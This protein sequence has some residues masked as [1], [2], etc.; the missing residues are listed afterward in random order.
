M[1]DLSTIEEIN[2]SLDSNSGT[3]TQSNMSTSVNNEHFYQI[4]PMDKFDGDPDSLSDWLAMYDTSAKALEWTTIMM[5]K[6]F[7]LHLSGFASK[8]YLQ[9]T[10]TERATW[11]TLVRAFR[12][13][14]SIKDNIQTNMKEFC[15][16]VQKPNEKVI[17][18]GFALKTAAERAIQGD[19][20]SDMRKQLLFTQFIT[21]LRPEIKSHALLLEVDNFDDALKKA[22]LI[23][24]NGLITKGI[25]AID[26]TND[27]KMYSIEDVR[28]L[29]KSSQPSPKNDYCASMSY[30]GNSPTPYRDHSNDRDSG[31]RRNNY[32]RDSSRNRDDHNYRSNRDYSHDRNNSYRSS[33][34]NYRDN[35][36]DRGYDRSYNDYRGR[37]PNRQEFGSKGVN[38]FDRNISDVR[39]K[40]GKYNADHTKPS[41]RDSMYSTNNSKSVNERYRSQSP[42]ENRRPVTCYH[43]GENGHVKTECRKLRNENNQDRERVDRNGKVQCYNCKSFGHMARS[44]PGS[45]AFGGTAT[46]SRKQVGFEKPVNVIER[47]EEKKRIDDIVTDLEKKNMRILAQEVKEQG[48]KN[49]RISDMFYRMATKIGGPEI[50]NSMPVGFRRAREAQKEWGYRTISEKNRLSEVLWPHRKEYHE[51]FDEDMRCRI[52]QHAKEVTP[53]EYIERILR[54]ECDRSGRFLTKE[55]ILAKKREDLMYQWIIGDSS[56]VETDPVKPAVEDAVV[57]ETESNKSLVDNASIGE[58]MISD[59]FVVEKSPMVGALIEES[60]GD[61]VPLIEKSSEVDAPLILE[62][63][64]DDVEILETNYDVLFEVD[65]NDPTE[66]TGY[67]TMIRQTDMDAEINED[68]LSRGVIERIKIILEK[69]DTTRTEIGE[70]INE[71]LSLNAKPDEL[72]QMIPT[73]RKYGEIIPYQAPVKV[74]LQKYGEYLRKIIK[75]DRMTDLE[76][77]T[78]SGRQFTLTLHVQAKV[79]KLRKKLTDI[80]GL[81]KGMMMIIVVNG[82]TVDD[83]EYLIECGCIPT[84]KNKVWI[85]WEYLQGMEP[86]EQIRRFEN[87]PDE[88][89]DLN[90]STT[91][92]KE[93]Y[94]PEV[95]VQG[96]INRND[97]LLNDIIE[98]YGLF[99]DITDKSDEPNVTRAPNQVNKDVPVKSS[100]T[101]KTPPHTKETPMQTLPPRPPGRPPKNEPPGKYAESKKKQ[102]NVR[103]NRVNNEDRIPEITRIQRTRDESPKPG[104]SR[105][106]RNDIN[107]NIGDKSIEEIAQQVGE[108]SKLVDRIKKIKDPGNEEPGEEGWQNKTALPVL[109]LLILTLLGIP[110]I[111][112]LTAYDCEKPKEGPKYSLRDIEACPEAIPDKFEKS[113]R[114]SYYVYQESDFLRTTARECIVKRAQSAW[115]CGQYSYTAMVVPTTAFRPINISTQNCETAFQTGKIRIDEKLEASA[116]VG[117]KTDERFIRQGRIDSDGSCGKEVYEKTVAGVQVKN[118]VIVED[119]MVELKEYQVVFDQS[120]S[121]MMG[122]EY[123]SALHTE[124]FTGESTIIYKVNYRECTLALLKYLEFRELRGSLFQ[125]VAPSTEPALP[126]RNRTTSD[127]PT[128][129]TPT[130]IVSSRGGDM[131]KLL[132][133]DEASRC[134]KIVRTTNY[135]GI[136]VSKEEVKEAKMRIAKEDVNMNH[137]FNNKIDFLYHKNLMKIER[138]YQDLVA[139]DC[140]LNREIL[141]TK[142]AVVMTNQDMV[143]PLLPLAEG[144][145]ARVMGEAIHTYQCKK[146]EVSLAEHGH[147]TNE[148]PV[149]YK[150]EKYFAEPIT[151]VLV[152]TAR[153]IACSAVLSPY[154]WHY[155][156]KW[157]SLPHRNSVPPPL[158]IEMM[159]LNNQEQF[160]EIKSMSEGGIYSQ[161]EINEARK[162]LLFPEKRTR[163]LTEIVYRVLGEHGD[164]SN[165]NFDLLLSPDHFK[166]AAHATL[167]KIWGKFLIFGQASAGLMGIYII[168]VMIKVILSQILNTLHIYRLAGFTWKMV[169]G[170]CPLMARHVLFELNLDALKRNIEKK[171]AA[172]DIEAELI[173]NKDVYKSA[174]NKECQTLKNTSQDQDQIHQSPPCTYP[175]KSIE[176]YQQYGRQYLG[177]AEND[178]FIIAEVTLNGQ[179][180]KGL[181]DTGASVTSIKYD[182]LSRRQKES[183]KRDYRKFYTIN[184]TRVNVRGICYLKMKLFNIT[185]KREVR[186]IDDIP[187]DCVIGLDVIREL[188]KRQIKW[189]SFLPKEKDISRTTTVSNLMM[190]MMRGEEPP[191]PFSD[192]YLEE[193]PN[194][195][196]QLGCSIESFYEEISRETSVERVSPTE[197]II[198]DELKESMR[199]QLNRIR[200]LEEENK[201]LKRMLASQESRRMANEKTMSEQGNIWIA[202]KLLLTTK[203]NMDRKRRIEPVEVY[204]PRKQVKRC[205][206]EKWKYFSQDDKTYCT[207]CIRDGNTPEEIGFHWWNSHGVYLTER[208][209]KEKF[210]QLPTGAF[211][212]KRC[213]FVGMSNEF[214]TKSGALSHWRMSHNMHASEAPPA[215][216]GKLHWSIESFFGITKEPSVVNALDT[217]YGNG[218]VPYMKIRING[219]RVNALLDTGS[220]VTLINDKYIKTKN[221]CKD[222]L[223]GKGVVGAT[224][225]Q[226]NLMGISECDFHIADQF[227]RHDAYITAKDFFYDAIIGMDL[228]TR[229]KNI[230]F[231]F[232]K[233]ILVTEK[234]E[235]V[236]EDIEVTISETI[237][238]PPRSEIIVKGQMPKDITD[239]VL[240]EPSSKFMER[241]EMPVTQGL[242]TVIK[243][244]IPV[245]I[246]NVN[247]KTIKLYPGT[248]IG[249]AMPIHDLTEVIHAKSAGYKV[250]G[251]IDLSNCDIGT[252]EQERLRDVLH[253]FDEVMAKHEYDLGKT[254]VIKHTLPLLDEQ[255]IKQRAY[256]IPYAQQEE[257]KKLIKGMEENEIIRRSSSPWTSPV[258]M[259][260]KKDGSMR[261]CVDYRKLNEITRKDTYPLPRIDEMLDKL[262]RSVIFTTLDL[263]SGYW[264][265][266]VEESDKPKTAFSTGHDLWEFN[267]LPF[268]LT[269]APATFQRCMN[270]LLMDTA[271]AM[272]Y[273]DDIIIFSTSFEEHLE[274]LRAVLDRLWTAGLKIKP[275]KCEFARKKVKFLGHIVSANGIQPDPSNTEKVKNFKTPKT[276]KEVQQFL[277][278]ASYYRRFIKNFAHI[279]APLSELTKKQKDFVWGDKQQAAFEELKERL[280]NPPILRY[281][282]MSADFVLMTDAS[283]FAIGAV[284]GQKVEKEKDHVIAYAS[285]GL[286]AHEKNYSTIEREAL[287]IVFATKQFRHYIWAKKVTLLTDQRPLVWLMKHK[288]SSS[289]L[290]RW[291]LQLQEYN[292]EIQYRAGKANANADC[293]SRLDEERVVAAISRKIDPSALTMNQAQE[294]DDEII[295]IK[296]AIDREKGNHVRVRKDI[297]DHVN[298]NEGKYRMDKGL[299]K[300]HDATDELI[301]LPQKFRTEIMMEYHDGALGGHLSRKKTLGRIKKRYFW[302]TIYADV[303]QWCLDCQ[304]CATR[305]DTGKRTKVPLKPIPPPTSPMEV[306]AMDIVGP[307]P[308]TISG[309]KYIIVFCDYLTKWVEAYPMPNQK[310]ETIA[311]IFVEKIVFRYGVPQKLITDQGTNFL[312]DLMNSISKIFQIMRI[313]TSPYHPQTDGL[314][315]RFNRTLTSMLSSYVNTQQTDWDVHIP[316]CLFAYRNAPHAS[317]GETPFYLMYL[318]HSR[319]PEDVKWVPPQS[320]YMDVI[321]YKTLMMERLKTAWDKAN[322]KMKYNQETMKENYDRKTREHKF[323]VGDDVLIHQ[324][325][326][327]KGLSPKLKR[328][329]KGPYKVLQVTSTNLKLQNKANK[330]AEPIIVHVNRCKL[331]PPEVKKPR[332]ELRSHKNTVAFIGPT[333]QV[334]QLPIIINGVCTKGIVDTGSPI[335]IIASRFL[336]IAQISEAK[337]V[338]KSNY[339]TI[340]GE[341]LQFL[342]I[343]STEFVIGEVQFTAKF[344]ILNNI[345]VDGI[346]GIDVISTISYLK[347]DWIKYVQTNTSEMTPEQSYNSI[348]LITREN[349]TRIEKDKLGD[350][351]KT[352]LVDIGKKEKLKETKMT[353]PRKHVSFKIG[354][355]STLIIILVLLLLSLNDSSAEYVNVTRYGFDMYVTAHKILIR[356]MQRIPGQ[357]LFGIGVYDGSRFVKRYHRN[358]GYTHRPRFEFWAD[359]LKPDT[360]HT[361]YLK[362]FLTNSSTETY[363]NGRWTE[364][365]MI[366]ATRPLYEKHPIVPIKV[367]DKKSSVVKFERNTNS[368]IPVLPKLS[369]SAT[370][371]NKKPLTTLTTR[372]DAYVATSDISLV[373]TETPPTVSQSTTPK[374]LI[375]RKA[376]T[377]KTH[378]TISG[379]DYLLN[380]YKPQIGKTWKYVPYTKE[381]LL[382][383]RSADLYVLPQ[384]PQTQRQVIGKPTS[385]LGIILYTIVPS[386]LGGVVICFLARYINSKLRIRRR[387]RL[388][389]KIK[390]KY[391]APPRLSIDALF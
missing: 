193:L 188:E 387:R 198:P 326:T 356:D 199:Y 258:V 318:R 295:Q 337:P 212:C 78:S 313:H 221:Y 311:Q 385:T 113:A 257:V 99:D 274:D 175:V 168:A 180:R 146:V 185:V 301:V 244:E 84:E 296:K 374:S 323:E 324:P 369:N 312:G 270:F 119:Y 157:I 190:P 254:S 4:I 80:L 333:N 104:G 73:L 197:C 292:L 9:L 201:K 143:A 43:C 259:V 382:K 82:H 72:T 267:V 273:I 336:T 50:A 282:D 341:K 314:V 10:D 187:I 114:A 389:D 269:G 62:E 17:E 8:A 217:P 325:F 173:T 2:S 219:Y 373:T 70:A 145:F 186:I 261:F 181:M 253:E 291:A 122:R 189:L 137:Y 264:Q 348:C 279:A 360:P 38:G 357:T 51:R 232:N 297:K 63:K 147:C 30:R 319:M 69:P 379:H 29:L 245:R 361:I 249:T 229:L 55:E 131:I 233:G 54:G 278:L 46:Q 247:M 23:E 151:R 61:S 238:I 211:E 192:V 248:R 256:R 176:E 106:V 223:I 363:K 148:L 334:L 28:S 172:E 251:E 327:T 167:E 93:L 262:G 71:L 218:V 149:S 15:S 271:H 101:Q 21:G 103:S 45:T 67:V 18:Y 246:S 129:D 115:Y 166:K 381:E 191:T 154:Y 98:T 142:L 222:Q 91:K 280:L 266:E 377:N 275:T 159:K 265:I 110:G 65:E 322:L 163:V 200:V 260:K 372:E 144:S 92:P 383:I 75:I 226:I 179:K 378:K 330:K 136:L 365:R 210:K 370:D 321:D 135:P 303:K 316:Y 126:V 241:Y 128:K 160:S 96:E 376:T 85:Y 309:N 285:R 90:T 138:V 31:Y 204:R 48:V 237:H 216:N 40:Y 331:A 359:D 304:I 156:N 58:T 74:I 7:P 240:F 287:A 32:Y 236:T 388:F 281:P 206:V 112:G 68:D 108:V 22:R 16:R 300:Y 342:G 41:Y 117:K 64:G 111:S 328:P 252:D 299:L 77:Q 306:T 177:F 230:R 329:F 164:A 368:L 36:R 207:L 375:T 205:Q 283:G 234:N 213:D 39:S 24:E 340:T 288:D 127:I 380:K 109:I 250:Y 118:A 123:C 94:T 83:D 320:Q 121:K 276:V 134:G 165:P 42:R 169:L 307:L 355:L 352:T 1:T 97:E 208:P 214:Y 184:N 243:K 125:E 33:N 268:G 345:V 133:K 384:T 308:E 11:D 170:C 56:K 220:S 49:E 89:V 162:F 196:K 242:C 35:S 95:K 290:I 178:E 107:V 6:R 391:D 209:F 367:F 203:P 315:E 284:L 57:R 339:Y 140:R 161:K 105:E 150:G 116:F 235:P 358:I 353:N 183:L 294:E 354:K 362:L 338:K 5:T 19:G 286:K 195:E 132:L 100:F 44:C 59:N 120:T 277:G 215:L 346:V 310:A 302:P 12:K 66:V 351:E 202:P 158:T 37:S 81:I 60:L 152:K 371:L 26:F 347:Q 293:L 139:S 239:D 305:R 174:E 272:V 255:P 344:W 13:K 20:T 289:R 130:V 227:L 194:L 25:R 225:D 171:D 53:Q 27:T 332:Y 88:I 364:K 79:K 349:K 224:G 102:T 52:N 263:Q 386:L 155:G 153:S 231:D 141:K 3:S 317:T 87:T 390:C 350:D 76:I 366:A 124:C 298:R 228:L 34:N 86:Y 335:S 14:L 47:E 182:C 343:L